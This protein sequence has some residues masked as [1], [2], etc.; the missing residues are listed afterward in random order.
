MANSTFKQGFYI[1]FTSTKEYI[2]SKKATPRPHRSFRRSYRED[3]ARDLETP[4]LLH[5]AVRTF[6]VLFKNWKLFGGLLIVVVLLNILLVGLLSEDAYLQIKN[7]A[8]QRFSNT[9]QVGDFAKSGLTLIATIT[10]G[11]FDQNLTDSQKLLTYLIMAIV[12]LVVIY[13]L[14]H[15]AAGHQPK[16]RDGLFNALAPLLSLLCIMLV[17]FIEL[18]PIMLVII[19][20]AAAVSTDFLTTPF[21]ALV[22]FIFATTMIILSAYLLA[23]S[24]VALIAVSSPGC[25]PLTALRLSATA[26]TGRRLRLIVRIIYLFF[27]LAVLWVITLLP[28]ILLDTWLKNSF[29]ILSNWPTVPFFLNLVSAFSMIYT[30]AYFYLYYRSILEYDQQN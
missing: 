14:R 29:E 4:G 10:T 12:W 8:G 11:G 26:I 20:Y 5:H 22:Y 13:L 1:K 24:F 2:W 17:I 9:T 28:I 21:Y 18:I 23:N 30:T 3:Y 6:G 16:L 19:T 27:V 15:L 7:T 25:Y